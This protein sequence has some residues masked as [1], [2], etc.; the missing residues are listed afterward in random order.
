M[1]YYISPEACISCGSCAVVCPIAAIQEG[2]ISYEITDDCLEC[3]A[4][5]PVCPIENIQETH[6]PGSRQPSTETRN[7]MIMPESPNK[8]RNIKE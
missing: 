1:A 8:N 3:G 6:Q 7:M 4:C 2:A 5:V